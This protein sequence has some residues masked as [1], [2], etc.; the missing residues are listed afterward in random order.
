MMVSTRVSSID[1]EQT[2]STSAVN[3]P[4]LLTGLFLRILEHLRPIPPA[5]LWL[6][7]QEFYTLSLPYSK[8]L[9][10]CK[11][12]LDSYLIIVD[13]PDSIISRKIILWHVLTN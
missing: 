5:C 9:G 8:G 10:L 3:L 1:T 12:Y 4:S 7:Y 2:E 6:T 13:G 11:L